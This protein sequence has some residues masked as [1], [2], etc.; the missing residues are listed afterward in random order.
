MR[1]KGKLL[2]TF[3]LPIVLVG[4]LGLSGMTWSHYNIAA[5]VEKDSE[6]IQAALEMEI[7]AKEAIQGILDYLARQDRSSVKLY[8]ENI[9]DYEYFMS[10]YKSQELSSKESQYYNEIAQIHTKFKSYAENLISIEDRQILKIDRV[11]NLL[12]EKI[13][14][15]LDD[16]W[17]KTLNT[18]DAE[19]ETKHNALLEIEINIHELISAMRGYVLDGDPFLK[20]RALDSMDD[21]ENW[22]LKLSTTK[23]NADEEIMYAQVSKYV[24][25][26]KESVSLVMKLEDEKRKNVNSLEA[27]SV[28]MDKVLD[29]KIQEAAHDDLVKKKAEVALLIY[30]LLVIIILI[31]SLSAFSVWW[32][33]RRSILKPIEKIRGYADAI[34]RGETDINVTYRSK[35]ELGDLANSFRD[36]VINAQTLTGV[37]KALGE[38]KFDTSVEPRSNKDILA[39]SL[40]EMRDNLQELDTANKQQVWIKT[41]VANI[42]QSM[43]GIR[44]LQ[45]LLQAVIKQLSVTVEAGVGT[46]YLKEGHT[47]SDGCVF[48][49]MGSYAYAERKGLSQE[50]KLGEGIVGQCAQERSTIV[51]TEIPDSYVEI[52]SGCGKDKPNCILAVPVVHEEDIVGVMEFASFQLFNKPQREV[53][54]A[55]AKNLAIFIKNVISQQKTEEL[56]SQSQSLTEELQ[57]QQEELKASNEELEE[58]TKVLKQNEEELKASS[59]EL[60]AA[61]EE[62]EEKSERLK[63]KNED[64]A[65]KN[66]EVE[67]AREEVEQR[68]KDLALASKYKSEFLANMSHELRTPLNSL[69]ILSKDL[70]NNKTGNLTEKQIESAKVI[71]D[72]G[73]DLLTLINDILDLSKVESGKLHLD[74]TRLDMSGFLNGLKNQFDPI[75]KEKGLSFSIDIDPKMNYPIETD[76]QRLS[77][78][79]K[80]LCFNAVKFTESGGIKIKVESVANDT[81][82]NHVKFSKDEV[83]AI[84]VIDTGIGITANKQRE[85]FEAFQQ[86]DGSTNRNYGGTGLGLAISRAMTELL[87][88]EIVLTSEAGEGSNFTIIIPMRLSVDN[89]EQDNKINL[90]KSNEVANQQEKASPKQSIQVKECEQIPVFIDDDRDSVNTDTKSLL[91]IED[92]RNFAKILQQLARD[93]GY[94]TLC[95]GDG[96]SGLSLAKKYKPSA[97]VLDIGLPDVDGLQVLEQLKFDLDTRHIAIHIVSAREESPEYKQKGA[98]GYLL[99]PAEAEELPAVFERIE[100]VIDNKIKNVL[101]VEDDESSH[102][103]IMHLIGN[104]NV[105]IDKAFNGLEAEEKIIANKY[106]CIILDLCLPDISGFELLKKLKKSKIDAPPVIVYTGRELDED[107]HNELRRYASSIVLKGAESPERLIDEISLFLHSVESDL[108]DKQKQVIQM[109]HNSEQILQNRRVL[110]VDDDVRNVFALSSTLED[111]GLDIIVASNGRVALDKLKEEGKIELVI[112]DIMMPVMD[113]YEAMQKIREQDVYKEL[114]IIALTAKAMTGDRAKCIESGANDYITKPVDVEKLVSMIKVWLFR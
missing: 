62:L 14:R 84:S 70:E 85:I 57:A 88:G 111:F 73:Q 28:E 42:G 95:A 58:K 110:L 39:L 47:K 77:Q 19:Y 12:N 103:A 113:G 27:L 56:L 75:V 24:K 37:S 82:L 92:D 86:G 68:A 7:N 11:K 5:V 45:Q 23:L 1:L 15:L 105:N 26:A 17:Q 18:S 40:L 8:E 6:K 32:Y 46:I 20:N 89:E 25:A 59:E 66:I 4:I 107:E 64:I 53:I 50:F 106:D 114:P 22:L 94:L 100:S 91:I 38:G 78:I 65:K 71:H 99:K 90:G 76:E 61:N 63:A 33:S 35:D 34:A 98:I 48:K 83:M 74:I 104:E 41:Q 80:N 109:L 79:I 72:G 9:K 54:N 112:M 55:V 108:P 21:I 30:A 43:Q 81:T 31:V 97:I 10:V 87:G 3:L 29:D 52:T 69:L 102:L 101:V 49:L 93:K 67:E 96:H 44:D 13:E 36:L 51:I 16:S 60:Q 2:T